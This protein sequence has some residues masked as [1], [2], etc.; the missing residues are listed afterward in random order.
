[1]NDRRSRALN[2][3]LHSLREQSKVGKPRARTGKPKR[4]QTDEEIRHAQQAKHDLRQR[5]TAL[6]DQAAALGIEVRLDRN[7]RILGFGSAPLPDKWEGVADAMD[8]GELAYGVLSGFGHSEP[9]ALLRTERARPTADPDVM[10]APTALELGWLLG[11]LDR[12][13]DLHDRAVGRWML[14]AGQPS[15]VWELAKQGD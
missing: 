2:L 4:K 15:E 9:W 12:V 6:E 13:L 8:E 3:R 5:C 1:M 14:L 7:G 11:I 10:E